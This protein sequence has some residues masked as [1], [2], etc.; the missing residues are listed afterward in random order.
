[1]EVKSEEKSFESK[2]KKTFYGYYYPT[3]ALVIALIGIFGALTCILTMI[4][5]IPVPATQGYINIGDAAVMLTAL[6]FG[7]IVGSLAGGIGSA[8]AD[9]ILGY[10][11]YAPAT[12]IIKGLEGLIVGLIANPRKISKRIHYRDIIAVAIG[13]LIMV[14]GYFIYE[15]IIYGLAAAL[16]EIVLNGLIQYGIGIGLSLLIIIPLRKS[17]KNAM[18][19]VFDNVFISR[20]SDSNLE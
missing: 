2:G 10:S 15:I 16:T 5:Q 7:P 3:N 20:S 6:L 13:G 11:I 1:M 17:L 18:P 12:L 8:L 4:P 14:F 19:Q 9:I